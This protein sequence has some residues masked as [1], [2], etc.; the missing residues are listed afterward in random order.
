MALLF[1]DYLRV[2]PEDCVTYAKEKYRLM[3]LYK[4]DRPKYVEGKAPVIWSILQKAHIWSQQT[5]WKPGNS[6]F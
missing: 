3:E 6:D 1:R 4:N 5:G 2:H